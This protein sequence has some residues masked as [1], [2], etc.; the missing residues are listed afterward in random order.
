MGSTG[1]SCP[2]FLSFFAYLI[3]RFL[4]SPSSCASEETSGDLKDLCPTFSPGLGSPCPSWRLVSS[5]IT[6]GSGLLSLLIFD[7]S[8]QLGVAIEV[9]VD[10]RAGQL[11]FF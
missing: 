6:H 10:F 3:S 5:E 4:S 9:H 11:A 8:L 1:K 7:R 2:K